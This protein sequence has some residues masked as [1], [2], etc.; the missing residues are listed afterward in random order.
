MIEVA[1]LTKFYGQIPAITDVSFDVA[2]GEIIGFLGPNAAGKSTTMRI[3][4]GF[5]PAT[6]G[7][8]CV[9]GFDVAEDPLSVKSRVGYLPE[10]VPLYGEM[11][12]TSFLRYVA[13]IKGVP[14]TGIVNEVGHA[15]ERAGLTEMA[16][17]PIGNLSKGYRQRVGL[18]QALIGSPPVLILDEPTV[19]L[20][21][22]QIIEIRNMIR[23]L[24]EGHTILLSSH[25]LPE[26]AMICNRVLIIHQGRIVA[27]EHMSDLAGGEGHLLD[28]EAG[29]APNRVVPVMRAVDG[30]TQVQD[31]GNGRYLVHCKAKADVRESLIQ[32]LVQGGLQPRAIIPRERTLEDVFVQAISRE[33]SSGE[34]DAAAEPEENAEPLDAVGSVPEDD[35]AEGEAAPENDVAEEDAEEGRT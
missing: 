3:L 12:V 23:D 27:E 20:D 14:R 22:K 17:R 26:V 29:G 8:A 7:K 15:M 32:A 9:A 16:M 11:L 28:V 33:E 31:Q 21:P 10:N 19:G 1:G 6:E 18:A 24:A 30:V 25:I 34:D 5:M 4:T 13:E 35:S 2:Q